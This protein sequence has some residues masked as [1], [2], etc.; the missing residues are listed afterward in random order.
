MNSLKPLQWAGIVLGVGVVLYF[1][2]Q[3]LQYF[4]NVS[5]L[6]GV[7]MLEILL[8]SIWKYEQ[9]FFA[10][11]MIAFVWAATGFPFQGAWRGGRCEFRAGAG[12]R[13]RS[14][15]RRI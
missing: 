3:H 5:L 12:S 15:S 13:E 2:Y 14:S 7:L 1:F 4:G 9:R 8:A 6:E 11:L 10:L